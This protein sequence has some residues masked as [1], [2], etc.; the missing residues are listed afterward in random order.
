MANCVSVKISIFNRWNKC[1]LVRLALICYFAFFCL[2]EQMLI[3]CVMWSIVK[4]FLC[5]EQITE[6]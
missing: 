2:V 5:I 3:R 1:A 4:D 6:P